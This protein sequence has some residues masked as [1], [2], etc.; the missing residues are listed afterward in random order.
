ML[1]PQWQC[2]QQPKGSDQQR[3][4]DL[5]HFCDGYKSQ[6]EE[7]VDLRQTYIHFPHELNIQVL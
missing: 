5:L 6:S 1:E 4:V 2:Q 7:K 3:D